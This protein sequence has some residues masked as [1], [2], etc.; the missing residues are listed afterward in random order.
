MAP[1]AALDVRITAHEALE[2]LTPWLVIP[3]GDEDGG[4]SSQARLMALLETH[5]CAMTG[6]GVP[7]KSHALDPSQCNFGRTSDFN[8]GP[9]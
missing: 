3:A 5:V 7:P 6:T 4:G 2:R 8:D 1:A 9:H